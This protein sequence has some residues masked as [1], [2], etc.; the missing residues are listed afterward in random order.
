VEDVEIIAGGE[1]FVFIDAAGK[2]IGRIVIRATDSPH[3]PEIF[4]K[5]CANEI[6]ALFSSAEK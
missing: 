4:A 2:K 5:E 6:Y 3:S 1:Q